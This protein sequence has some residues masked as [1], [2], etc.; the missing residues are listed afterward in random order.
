MPT[1]K[2]LF[3]IVYLLWFSGASFTN[4]DYLSQYLNKT[5]SFQKEA[6]GMVAGWN[7]KEFWENSLVALHYIF[8]WM[9]VHKSKVW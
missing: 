7:F 4:K 6:K 1:S 8:N 3:D 9:K 2:V 5:A